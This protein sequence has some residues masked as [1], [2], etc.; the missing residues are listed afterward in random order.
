MKTSKTVTMIKPI[1]I[2]KQKEIITK[3][4]LKDLHQVFDIIN[5]TQKINSTHVNALSYLHAKIAQDLKIVYKAIEPVTEKQ[6]DEWSFQH[7]KQHVEKRMQA[8]T[9]AFAERYSAKKTKSKIL[10]HK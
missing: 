6:I 7:L 8:N 4:V 5:N 3:K 1:I 10:K 9:L 2:E